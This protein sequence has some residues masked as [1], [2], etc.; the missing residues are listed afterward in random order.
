ME[1]NIVGAAATL[2]AVSSMLLG[3][4]VRSARA[5]DS[6]PV[7]IG[8]TPDTSFSPF[9]VAVD[10]GFLK[11]E[12]VNASYKIGQGADGTQAVMVGAEQMAPNSELPT[13]I[14]KAKGGKYT[15]VANTLV[16]PRQNGVAAIAAI[17][18]PADLSGRKVGI[19]FGTSGEYFFD[20]YVAHYGLDKA[21][22]SAINVNASDLLPALA[23]GDV[24]AY[25]SWEPWL[26]KASEVRKG[27]HVLAY[28][29]ENGIY[30]MRY[31]LNVGDS[32]AEQHPDLVEG[33]LRGLIKA[34]SWMMQHPKQAAEVVGNA[35]RLDPPTAEQ[36][37]LT[38]S[39]P[40]NMTPEA[41]DDYE[42]AAD[43]LH[44]ENK[45]PAAIEPKTLVNGLF[46]PKFLKAVAPDA[47]T[48][49]P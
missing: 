1:R 11:A 9:Y 24:D 4:T 22:I 27:A 34:S 20:R 49:S 43:W 44:Q 33:V 39:Y 2:L 41:G 17:A 7:L 35:I 10:K 36:M 18:K 47:V 45:I 46:N 21:K 48:L 14:N 38:A 23:R 28:S 16:A 26:S 19:P 42:Q 31:C 12:G 6:T 15:C 40:I 3:F 32:F 13:L 5:A 8:L 25:F 29:G 30:V 37:M